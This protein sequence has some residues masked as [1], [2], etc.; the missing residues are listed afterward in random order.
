MTT[1]LPLDPALDALI[2]R[3]PKVELH[4][5][6]EGT[7]EPELAFALAER[8]GLALPY[9]DVEAM[10]AAYDFS[11]LQSFLDLY[12]AACAVLVTR[13]DFRDLTVA[14]LRRAAKDNVRHVEPFFDPQ[15][16]TARGV[17]FDTVTAGI[18]DGLDIG[19]RELGITSGLVMSFLRDLSEQSAEETLSAATPWLSRLVAVGLDSAEIGNPPEKFAAVFARA[20]G[21]GLR[22]VAHAGEEAAAELVTRT[23]DVL[24]VSRVDHGVRSADDP[25]LVARLARDGIPLTV[26]PL[27]NTRLRVFEAMADSP[28]ADL[29]HAGVRVTIN[30]DDPAYFGGYIAENF[31]AAASALGLTREDLYALSLNAIEGSFAPEPRRPS[32]ERSSMRSSLGAE[33]ESGDRQRDAVRA[34]L[35]HASGDVSLDDVTGSGDAQPARLHLHEKRCV[36]RAD[37]DLASGDVLLLAPT[38]DYALDLVD[39][40]VDTV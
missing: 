35:Q 29:L 23:L 11:D 4:V 20:R 13:E 3:M 38:H 40:V 32:S 22:A 27:S 14:Y 28:L 10:R 24:G 26:C 36:V 1:A 6:L 2:G 9:A 17:A 16:H 5:H 8:N 30:S 18:L 25:A 39:E 7:L 37:C 34:N 19:E 12:Y 33:R 21:L 15:T 31:R